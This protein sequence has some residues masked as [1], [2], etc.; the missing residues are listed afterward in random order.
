MSDLH[1]KLQEILALPEN[2][3][4][5][6]VEQQ[7]PEEARAEWKA[8]MAAVDGPKPDMARVQDLTLPG[9]AGNMAARLYVPHGL[10]EGPQAGLIYFHGGGFIRGDIE[11]HDGL[12]RMLA[13]AGEMI[14]I[15]VAYRLAPE[16]PFPA[17]FED[18]C[19]ATAH[20]TGHAGQFGLDENRIAVGGDS[21]GGNLAAAVCLAARDGGGARIRA[22]LL[23][24]PVTDLVGETESGRLFSRGYL[25]N[26]MPFYTASYL[27]AEGDGHHPH[28]SPLLASDH[29]GLPPAIIT[30]AGFDPLR[31][32][33]IAYGGKLKAAGVDV[34]HLHY[35][36]MIHGFSSL[37]GL[38]AEA[39]ASLEEAG[40]ALAGLLKA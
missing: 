19:A 39:D 29:S 6:P 36:D 23:L 37:R 11:T 3:D 20:I 18:A 21:A 15:S 38:L 16:H 30:T 33:G 22:Q 2:P 26:S 17:A 24:Y 28:A 14:V 7:T 27:G 25:L 9:P 1:P 5:V 35:A 4:A 8:D 12:C 13:Q 40:R 10:S 32:E 31:D 34:V